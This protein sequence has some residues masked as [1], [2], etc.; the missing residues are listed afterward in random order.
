MVHIF[1]ADYMDPTSRA[2]LAFLPENSN[3]RHS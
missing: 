2:K 1:G 3:P